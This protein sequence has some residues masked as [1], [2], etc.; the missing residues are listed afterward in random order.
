MTESPID[1]LNIYFDNKLDMIHTLIPGRIEKYYGHDQRKAEVKPVIKTKTHEGI[2]IETPSIDN[3]PVIFP[4]SKLFSFLYPIKK[5]DG[6]LI[7]F[8]ESS[9]GNF[10]DG[11]S[12]S[13]PED[14]SRFSLTDAICIPGLW[15]FKGVPSDT[16]ASIEITEDGLK[17]KFGDCLFESDGSK[18]TINGNFE[19]DV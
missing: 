2:V 3:V 19:V 13:E 1:A 8:C 11:Q 15:S 18:T 6:C 7:G 5:G 4:G 17:I 10:L 16:K 12:I 14:L 9:I